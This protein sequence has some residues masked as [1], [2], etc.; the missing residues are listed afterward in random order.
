MD[1][2]LRRKSSRKF[3]SRRVYVAWNDRAVFIHA[4]PPASD[5]VRAR[6]RRLFFEETPKTRYNYDNP[7]FGMHTGHFTQVVWKSSLRLGCAAENAGASWFWTCHFT[8]AGNMMGSFGSMVSKPDNGLKNKKPAPPDQGGFVV[9]EGM[10]GK[11][12]SPESS[13]RVPM[14]PGAMEPPAMPSEEPTF[15]PGF[16]QEPTSR[17]ARPTARSKRTSA[18]ETSTSE[19]KE[20]VGLLKSDPS[21]SEKKE[22]KSL[23]GQQPPGTR[24]QDEPGTVYLKCR[25]ALEE[26]NDMD[27]LTPL[28]IYKTVPDA[29]TECDDHAVEQCAAFTWD[30]RNATT[31]S[32]KNIDA[33]DVGDCSDVVVEDAHPSGEKSSWNTW[34]KKAAARVAQERADNNTGEIAAERALQ[35][36]TRLQK[37]IRRKNNT[38]NITNTTGTLEVTYLECSGFLNEGNSVDPK[39]PSVRIPSPEAA[40]VQCNLLRNCAAFTNTL[41]EPDMFYLKTAGAVP[42]ESCADVSVNDAEPS[43]TW[44]KKEENGILRTRRGGPDFPTLCCFSVSAGGSYTTISFLITISRSNVAHGEVLM[45]V[46]RSGRSGYQS[47]YFLDDIV[48][49]IRSTDNTFLINDNRNR[50]QPRRGSERGRYFPAPRERKLHRG[51]Y[52]VQRQSRWFSYSS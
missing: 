49:N 18:P 15:A 13:N 24:E 16:E 34:I 47:Q 46:L 6:V 22:N 25:G 10:V 20:K 52:V 36:K 12:G 45:D 11:C 42:T 21:I 32:L 29:A 50:G 30:G 39:S 40:Q 28:H 48:Y 51:G 38:T 4:A 17:P 26:G 23:Q 31:F 44:I 8:P 7:G 2:I 35:R 37:K 14:K 43:T 9:C 33:L 19:K 41:K 3:S 1:G 27:P 5:S